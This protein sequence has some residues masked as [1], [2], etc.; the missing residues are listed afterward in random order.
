MTARWWS[1]GLWRAAGCVAGLALGLS[2][3]ACEQGAP[4]D[5]RGQ[6]VGYR[7]GTEEDDYLSNG[8]RGN[9]LFTEINWAGSVNDDGDWDPGDVW[10]ELQN[11]HPRPIHLTGW[12][13]T[14]QTGSGDPRL[15]DLPISAQRPR[16]TY[17]IPA[18]RGG[19]PV[20]PS[21]FVV[22]ATRDDGAVE[23]PDYIIPD[24]KIPQDRWDM[25]LRD[26]DD[27]LLEGAGNARLEIFAGGYDLVTVR[28]MER[29]QI[30]FSNQGNRESNWHSY[31]LNPWDDD[32]EARMEHIREGFREHSY[33]S[34]KRANSVDYSGNGAAGDFD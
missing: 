18:R 2:L 30:L 21:E 3:G 22:I 28:S 7:A 1:L 26:L 24:L 12:Q 5:E 25:T 33:G 6:Q 31:G 4:G 17:L 8:E 16:V 13:I 10:I 11:K 9:V 29:S 34:P 15:D 23:D 19:Q 32:H 20:Q 14:I 27:R